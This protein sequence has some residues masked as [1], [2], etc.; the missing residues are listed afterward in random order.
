M[1][2]SAYEVVKGFVTVPG[3]GAA[4]GT[5]RWLDVAGEVSLRVAPILVV[6]S[7]S[8]F[9]VFVTGVFLV[10]PCSFFFLLELCTTFHTLT[11]D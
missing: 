1:T 3:L 7:S 11:R 6:P 4:P 2:D 9:F 5:V 8:V 10:E